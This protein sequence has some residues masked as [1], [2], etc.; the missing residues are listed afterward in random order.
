MS[1][2]IRSTKLL[3]DR[4]LSIFSKDIDGYTAIH[5]ATQFNH[6]TILE[7]CLL[8]L[9]AIDENNHEKERIESVECTTDTKSNLNTTLRFASSILNIQDNKGRTALHWACFKEHCIII[10][11]LLSKGADPLI[12]DEYGDTPLHIAAKN[13]NNKSISTFVKFAK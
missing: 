9:T 8:Y 7:F 1:G 3:I 6:C 12:Q 11:W 10:E 5:A 4:G 2:D 13:F